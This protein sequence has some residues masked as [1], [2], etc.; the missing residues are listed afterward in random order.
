MP[1]KVTILAVIASLALVGCAGQST[2][3]RSSMIERHCFSASTVRGFTVMDDTTVQLQVARGD[4]YELKLMTFCPNIDWNH[5][6]GLRNRSGS[7]LICTQDA[8]AVEIVMLDR[9]PTIGPESCRVRSI[10]KLDPAE[11]EA[12]RAAT[13]QKRVDREDA[14]LQPA[15]Q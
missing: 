11:I 7:T 9:G 10:R 12:Q 6:I 2:D 8:M 14:E 1:H 5:T 15:S 4:V 3:T 13:R